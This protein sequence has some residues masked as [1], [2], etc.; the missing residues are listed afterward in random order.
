VKHNWFKDVHNLLAKYNLEDLLI[1][2]IDSNLPSSLLILKHNICKRLDVTISK[3]DQKQIVK[4]QNS[5][6]S[7]L[8][9]VSRSHYI[10]DKIMNEYVCWSHIA[11]YVQRKAGIPGVV[12]KGITIILDALNSYFNPFGSIALDV[13]QLCRLN[14]QEILYHFFFDCPGYLHIRS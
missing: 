1:M 4:M 2:N 14:V 10:R 8:Y 12:F 3:L 6:K 7:S 13:C 11:L 5:S 9:Q